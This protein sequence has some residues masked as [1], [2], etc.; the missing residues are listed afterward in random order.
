MSTLE[1]L[2]FLQELQ[3]VEGLEIGSCT[4]LARA[5]GKVQAL[6]L[7]K[8]L[9][10]AL[11]SEEITRS[12]NLFVFSGLPFS[13]TYLY[14]LASICPLYFFLFLVNCFSKIDSKARRP[15]ALRGSP[16]I[17]SPWLLSMTK[18]SS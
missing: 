18:L 3:S 1:I 12:A 11:S 17:N 7:N 4:E 5:V 10:V 15:A 2:L 8:S 16:S 6:A 9:I 14:S 13:S